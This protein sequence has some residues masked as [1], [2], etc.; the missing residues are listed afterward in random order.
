MG[1][2]A[3]GGKK[4]RGKR[5]RNISGWGVGNKLVGIALDAVLSKEYVLLKARATKIIVHVRAQVDLMWHGGSRCMCQG[6]HQAF[7]QSVYVNVAVN[8][9]AAYVLCLRTFAE[10]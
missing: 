5:A 7:G 8:C 4:D 9:F 2:V 1:C 3:P 6:P 10:F